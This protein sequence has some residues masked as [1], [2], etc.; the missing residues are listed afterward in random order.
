MGPRLID[1]ELRLQ[2]EVAADSPFTWGSADCCMFAARCVKAMTGIDYARA[3]SYRD[4]F[5]AKRSLGRYGG[6]EGIA[7]HALGEPKSGLMAQ[8]GDVVLVQSPLNSL[9]ICLGHV[10]AAQGRDGVVMLPITAA[11]KAW[12]V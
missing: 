3:F 11:I 7:T 4:A 12:T 2:A 8:R 1:W 6:V 9:G 5:G 10:I